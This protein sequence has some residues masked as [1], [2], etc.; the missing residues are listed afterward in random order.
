M[1]ARRRPV[2][3]AARPAIAVALGSLALLFG[4]LATAS[5]RLLLQGCVDAHGAAGVLGMR[6]AV[7][8]RATDCP[9]GTLGAGPTSTSAVLL[10]SI[11]LPMLLAYAA[12]GIGGFGALTVVARVGAVLRQLVRRA[13][14]RAP[15]VHVV[16]ARAL[17]FP[18][19]LVARPVGRVLVAGIARRGPPVAA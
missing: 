15:R 9:D 7:L 1:T 19:H 17:N 2:A 8:R 14:A 12:L 6:L 13:V 5:S 18:G 10:L 4:T 11:A 16:V 3:A